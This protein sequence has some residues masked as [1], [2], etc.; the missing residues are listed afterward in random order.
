MRR[1]FPKI[2]RKFLKGLEEGPKMYVSLPMAIDV[3]DYLMLTLCVTNCLR[4]SSLMNV[5]IHDFEQPKN[6]QEIDNGYTFTTVTGGSNIAS[7]K[8]NKSR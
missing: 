7:T 6:H 3:R 2:K 4:S 1:K 8:T 5:N